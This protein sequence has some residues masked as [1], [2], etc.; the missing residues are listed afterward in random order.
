M[1]SETNHS[2]M[3]APRWARR[4]ASAVLVCLLAFVLLM[5]IAMALYPG[6]NWID[7]KAPGH[8]FLS[9][10]FCDLTQPV[11]LSG[12]NNRLGARVARLGMWCF[13]AALAGFFWLAIIATLTFADYLTRT[14]G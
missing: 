7:P 2:E 1:S 4:V 12:V 5:A 13:A 9:N 8:R 14:T 3:L 6:G 10:F 11:S